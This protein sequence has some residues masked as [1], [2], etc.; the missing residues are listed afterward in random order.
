MRRLV[1]PNFDKDSH[2]FWV[3]FEEFT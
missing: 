3:S 1:E 2:N